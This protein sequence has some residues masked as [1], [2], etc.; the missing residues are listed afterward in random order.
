[1]A[2]VTRKGGLLLPAACE[3]Q[4]HGLRGWG[5]SNINNRC[6]LRHKKEILTAWGFPDL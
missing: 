1:M 5:G 2:I 3:L 4:N 6:G